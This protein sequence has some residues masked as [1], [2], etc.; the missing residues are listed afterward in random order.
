[1]QLVEIDQ[2]SWTHPSKPTNSVRDLPLCS[3]CALAKAKLS[4]F[5]GPIT[6]PDQIGGLIFADVQGPFEVPTPEGNVYKIGIIEEK[7][8]YIWMTMAE[9]NK[10]DFMLGH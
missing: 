8:K 4:S 7:P 6:I 2:L 9:P 5:R 10:V 3:Y 1:M